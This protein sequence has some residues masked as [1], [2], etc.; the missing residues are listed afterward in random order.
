MG[1]RDGLSEE[2]CV[3]GYPDFWGVSGYPISHSLTPRLFEIVGGVL[4]FGS[5][6]TIFLEARSAEE[7]V[8]GASELEGALWISCT[9]PLKNSVCRKL[10][11]NVSDGLEAVNQIVRVNGEWSGA[12]TDGD[13]FVVA[14]RHIGLN[15]EGKTLEIK[16]GGSTARSIALSWTECGGKLS[17]VQGRRVLSDGPWMKAIA[18]KGE[19]PDISIDTDSSPGHEL[20][21][22]DSQ[23]RRLSISY[24][25]SS[26]YDD[27]AVVMLAAQHLEAWK[28]LF[29][30]GRID[31][32]PSLEE[33][34]HLL[35]V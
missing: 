29:A 31:Q 18:E 25:K 13:G 22:E 9:S 27:F 23:M 7:F 4:G 34:L 11:I 24:G 1:Y 15:P 12:N 17:L 30:P 3:L 19:V 14:C 32:L 28:A 6:K 35:S 33:V 26:S 21:I 16:G 8:K 2:A 20:D 5:V 10:G